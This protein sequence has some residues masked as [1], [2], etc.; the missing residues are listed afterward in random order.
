[1]RTVEELAEIMKNKD[2]SHLLDF[3]K[4]YEFVVGTIDYPEYGH[5]IL[6][7]EEY[8]EISN[9]FDYYLVCPN[10][11][12]YCPIRDKTYLICSK[13]RTISSYGNLIKEL[14]RHRNHYEK[15]FLYMISKPDSQ[16]YKIRFAVFPENKPNE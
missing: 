4:W 14:E 16:T 3:N 6:P 9:F 13:S 7:N 10:Y 5:T 8:L 12:Y 11:H 1:M 2:N 15:L